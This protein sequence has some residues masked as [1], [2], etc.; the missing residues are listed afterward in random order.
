MNLNIVK[1]DHEQKIR[2]ADISPSD[3]GDVDKT[4]A[5]KEFAEL[6]AKL[7]DL[8]EWLYA[9]QRNSVL[10]VLQGMDTSGKDGTIAR[11]MSNINPQGCAVASFK[12]PTEQEAS[13]DFLWR[14]HARTPSRGMLHIFNRSH[15]EDVL[16]TR[17]HHMIDKAACQERYQRIK[18]FEELL[19]DDNTIILKFFLHISKKEQEERLLAR[20]Q[21]QEK[22]WKLSPADW[23]ERAFWDEYTEAYEDAIGAT[24]AKHAP[25]YI[26][27]AD[28]KWYRNVIIAKCLVETLERYKD[29]W[30]V[31]LKELGEQRLKELADMRAGK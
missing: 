19:A 18:Q 20:E 4:A 16:I 22:A 7:C 17:V 13:H 28:H 25:W 2:L 5:A 9:A 6:G 8:Q 14:V 12:V 15:Y 10:M 1:L 21:D 26:V 11:V 27:P 24:S 23:K 3:T 30:Q 29:D 31:T